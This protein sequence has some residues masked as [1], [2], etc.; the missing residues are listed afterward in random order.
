MTLERE[1]DD[2]E[3]GGLGG[4]KAVF[5]AKRARK[6][7]KGG[8]KW[9]KTHPNTVKSPFP[10]NKHS[11]ALKPNRFSGHL[12]A[13]FYPARSTGTDGFLDKIF[14]LVCTTNLLD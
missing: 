5:A 4:S 14:Y 6:R 10:T 7:P 3:R 12:E 11:T 8:R 9:L 1:R 2:G 13:L